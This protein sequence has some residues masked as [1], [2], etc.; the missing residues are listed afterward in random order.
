MSKE[1]LIELPWSIFVHRDASGISAGPPYKDGV[2]EGHVHEV[3]SQRVSIPREFS[4]RTSKEYLAIEYAT[5]AANSFHSLRTVCQSVSNALNV[6]AWS[7]PEQ[8]EMILKEIIAE[9]CAGLQKALAVARTRPSICYKPY[10]KDD[11]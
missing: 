10:P 5:R 4:L 11:E 7:T 3:F 6:A 9:E 1:Q 2:L 8:A